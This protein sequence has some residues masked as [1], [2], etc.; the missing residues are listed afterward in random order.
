VSSAER[1]SNR[2]LFAVGKLQ[3][4]AMILLVVSSGVLAG[5]LVSSDLVVRLGLFGLL[6]MVNIATVI[7]LGRLAYALKEQFS[8]VYIGLGFFPVLAQLAVGILIVKAAVLLR[9][10]GLRVG[11]FGVSHAQLEGLKTTGTENSLA[12][13]L[14]DD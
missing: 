9:S 7:F 2:Q 3:K 13:E 5:M 12:S 6:A 14:E 11:P 10:G 1:P 8:W 4:V